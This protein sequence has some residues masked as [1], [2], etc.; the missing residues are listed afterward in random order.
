MSWPLSIKSQLC[1]M[2]CTTY[3]IKLVCFCRTKTMHKLTPIPVE[4]WRTL[5]VPDFCMFDCD[6]LHRTNVYIAQSVLSHKSESLLM[7][8]KFYIDG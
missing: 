7:V 3:K 1:I 5:F 8:V 4:F 2:I 6:R